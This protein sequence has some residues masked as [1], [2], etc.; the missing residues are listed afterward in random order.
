MLFTF[1]DKVNK[2]LHSNLIYK[3]KGNIFI[4][5]VKPNAFMVKPNAISKLEPVSI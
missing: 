3:F 2:M 1:K 5:M 4:D